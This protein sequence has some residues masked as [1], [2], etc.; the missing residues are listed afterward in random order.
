M[1]KT[2]KLVCEPIS[3][4]FQENLVIVVLGFVFFSK[5]ATN[6]TQEVNQRASDGAR[7]ALYPLCLGFVKD[8]VSI[9]LVGNRD[10]S[11]TS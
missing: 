6:G 5:D 11:L 10:N 9:W 3:F 8:K 2:P 1:N 7:P 4:A